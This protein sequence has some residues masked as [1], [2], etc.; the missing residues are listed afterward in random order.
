MAAIAALLA[1]IVWGNSLRWQLTHLSAYQLFP[2]FGLLAFSLMWSH[3]VATV[4][5]RM[6][7]L[8]KKVLSRYFDITS[9]LV[10]LFIFL[11]PGLLVW[12]LWRDGFG[13]PPGSYLS[14]YVAPG[15]RWAAVLGTVSLFIFLAYETRRKFNARPWWRFVAYATDAAMIAVFIHGLEL[16][17]NLH[18][19]W[20]KLVWYFYGVI[21]GAALIYIYTHREI[22]E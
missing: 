15:L 22:S 6:G 21:L 16:G 1:I 3:Y 9:W 7:G 17:T 4:L 12:Q 14:H 8:D 5:R 19:N 20:Y 10:L 11:H 13:L 2:L 18:Q